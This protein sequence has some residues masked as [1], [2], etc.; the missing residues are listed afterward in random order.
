M[1][2]Y[3]LYS[4][5][6]EQFSNIGDTFCIYVVRGLELSPL[7]SW[8]TYLFSLRLSVQNKSLSLA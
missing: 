1:L 8:H 6:F 5:S 7:L 3:I 4:A 2:L